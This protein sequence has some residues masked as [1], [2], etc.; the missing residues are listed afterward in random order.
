MPK[1]KPKAIRKPLAAIL[2]PDRE[3]ND[4]D[5]ILGTFII[6]GDD[7]AVFSYSWNDG[8]WTPLRSL[9]GSEA[10]VDEGDI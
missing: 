5:T 2:T 8:Y 4:G 1:T 3:T 6:V 7:G 9:P 10:A